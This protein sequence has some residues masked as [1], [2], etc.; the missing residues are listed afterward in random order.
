MA[1][2]RNLTIKLAVIGTRLGALP[3]EAAGRVWT[4]DSDLPL[5]E[6]VRRDFTKSGVD[7]KGFNYIGDTIAGFNRTALCVDNGRVQKLILCK[8]TLSKDAARQLIEK[9]ASDS[10][11]APKKVDGRVTFKIKGISYYAKPVGS[12]TKKTPE[13]RHPVM[14]GGERVEA[15]RIDSGPFGIEIGVQDSDWLVMNVATDKEVM[16]AIQEGRLAKGMRPIEAFLAM[17]D[18]KL[19]RQKVGDVPTWTWT[20][21]KVEMVDMTTFSGDLGSNL[22]MTKYS[23]KEK[24]VAKCTF[25]DG[26]VDSIEDEET[27]SK[28]PTE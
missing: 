14:G 26:K 28:P 10:Q 17:R 6:T 20:D 21:K 16:K 27:L 18:F 2:P 13:V 4:I 1:Q 23:A 15:G 24:I 9:I 11:S 19:Y 25:A 22:T 12:W 3:E 5:I 8:P 7:L